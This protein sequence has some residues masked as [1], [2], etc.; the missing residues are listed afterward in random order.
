MQIRNR[1]TE[2]RY[3]PAGEL[4]ANP[5]NWRTHPQ[6]QREALHGI[7]AEVG[8]AD[9]VIARELPDG[10]LELIDGHLRAEDNPDELIPV[11]VTDLNDE[12]AL[13]LLACLDPLAGM[14]DADAAVARCANRRN[15]DRERGA[16]GH[17][18]E[19]RGVVDKSRG[20]RWM[21]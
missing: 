6:A 12:E 4:R 5:R 8:Y 3:V 11:L 2:L 19:S 1:I 14:A 7:L 18:S 15:R 21:R 10:T 17:A 16:P 9:A 20:H 13:K